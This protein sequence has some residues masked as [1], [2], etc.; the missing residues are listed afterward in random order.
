MRLS[1]SWDPILPI[2]YDVSGLA[3]WHIAYVTCKRMVCALASEMRCAT[4]L[5]NSIDT[6]NLSTL[7]EDCM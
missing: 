5:M 1:R 4:I 3:V 6:S 2:G 7:P